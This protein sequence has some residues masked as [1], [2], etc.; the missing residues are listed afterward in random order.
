MT[1][2]RAT[3]ALCWRGRKGVRDEIG[4]D[5]EIKGP[6]NAIVKT[7]SCA[8][9]GADRLAGSCALRHRADRHGGSLGRESP[10]GQFA[11]CSAILM[12]AKQVVCIDPACPTG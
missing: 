12:G 8:L 9:C 5:P 2:K 3:K 7:S 11:V 10:V 4:P 6:R 1:R